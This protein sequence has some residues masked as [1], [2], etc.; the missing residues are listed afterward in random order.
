M[1]NH[2]H[3]GASSILFQLLNVSAYLNCV[4]LFF[5]HHT[6]F[7]VIDTLLYCRNVMTLVLVLRDVSV[8]S[9]YFRFFTTFFRVPRSICLRII[10]LAIGFKNRDFS[11]ASFVIIRM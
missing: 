5:N 7:V 2:S 9:L 3:C 10:F 6:W 8:Y 1:F 11:F 4:L